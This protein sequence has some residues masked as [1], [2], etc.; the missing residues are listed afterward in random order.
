[1]AAE[2]DPGFDFALGPLESEIMEIVWALG[3]WVTV[4]DVVEERER[5]GTSSVY[6][7]VKAVTQNLHDKGHLKKRPHGKQNAFSPT[8]AR[9]EFERRAVG[10]VVDP[11]LRH[12]RNPLLAHIV[13]ELIDDKDAI[14]ELEALLAAKRAK[15]KQ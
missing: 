6:S 8:L 12:H 2:R 4:T 1:M 5:R 10:R 11:L 9:D 15:R 13:N 14:A 7:T 3:G